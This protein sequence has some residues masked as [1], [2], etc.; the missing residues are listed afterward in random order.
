MQGGKKE[1]Q[2]SGL[3]SKM[4]H[5][6]TALPTCYRILYYYGDFSVALAFVQT[7]RERVEKEIE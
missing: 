5:S 3:R 4:E 2:R 7:V 1:N 6:G